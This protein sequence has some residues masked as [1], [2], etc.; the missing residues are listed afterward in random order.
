M[1]E[2]EQRRIPAS[3]D[4]NSENGMTR[5]EESDLDT[6]QVAKEEKQA[7]TRVGLAVWMM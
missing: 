4:G 6:E 5:R 1:D 2:K 7:R 3:R